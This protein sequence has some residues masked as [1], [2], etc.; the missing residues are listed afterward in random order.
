MRSLGFE[1]IAACDGEDALVIARGAHPDL[2]ITDVNMP[3]LNGFELCEKLKADEA[4]CTIPVV[5]VTVRAGE[6]DRKHGSEAGAK[7]YLVKPF[8][9]T[10]LKEIIDRL[11]PPRTS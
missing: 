6:H 3:R 7:A 4:T 9:L 1:C 8:H 2:I 10:D 11:L 5:F